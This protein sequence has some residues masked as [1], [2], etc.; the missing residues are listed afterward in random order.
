M[1]ICYRYRGNN[2]IFDQPVEAVTLGRPR[3]GVNVDIDLT[4]DLRVSRPHARISFADYQ[5]WI[6][7]LGSANGTELDGEPIKGKGKL[8]VRPSQTIRISDTTI[9]IELPQPEAAARSGWVSDDATLFVSQDI[10]L[11]ITEMIEAPT[12]V[13]APGQQIDANQAQ[14]LALLYELP[15][16]FGEQTEL[17]TLFQT[18]IE[19]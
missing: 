10:A 4:P 14:A 19:R 8:P 18:V 9:E 7:D 16:Q 3:H 11:D 17:D 15:L 5:Y 2:K 12:P 1:R 6:E 13:F